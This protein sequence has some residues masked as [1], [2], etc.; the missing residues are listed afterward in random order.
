VVET[1]TDLVHWTEANLAD[2]SSESKGALRT[3]TVRD[4]VSLGATSTRF[5]RLRVVSSEGSLIPLPY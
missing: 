1:S 2:V 5:L 3:I 4:A